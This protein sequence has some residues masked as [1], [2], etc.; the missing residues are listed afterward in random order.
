M[1]RWK[2]PDLRRDAPIDDDLDVVPHSSPVRVAIIDI[3]YG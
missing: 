1:G 3:G 2:S